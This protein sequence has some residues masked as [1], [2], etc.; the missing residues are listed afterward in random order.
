MMPAFIS[1]QH[2]SSVRC[3][4]ADYAMMFDAACDA[5]QTEVRVY[6]SLFSL[7]L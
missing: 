1:R 6:A 4:A 2:F 3:A 7:C 5:A